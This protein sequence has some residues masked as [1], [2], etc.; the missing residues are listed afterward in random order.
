MRFHDRLPFL[1]FIA[2]R[3]TLSMFFVDIWMGVELWGPD[4][5]ACEGLGGTWLWGF[6][7]ASFSVTWFTVAI[8]LAAL[9]WDKCCNN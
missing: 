8:L 4:A 2:T 1:G 9:V 6:G 7:L 3:I 5:R